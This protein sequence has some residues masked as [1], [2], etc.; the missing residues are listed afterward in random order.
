M[1]HQRGE[2]MGYDQVV[3]HRGTVIPKRDIERETER[4]PNKWEIIPS[5]QEQVIEYLRQKYGD[6]VAK[7]HVTENVK[8]PRFTYTDG[9]TYVK[10]MELKADGLS[11]QKIAD[12]YGITRSMLTGRRKNWML[13][14]QSR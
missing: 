7:V 2:I 6:A 12:R 11:D 4:Y 13:N 8:K 3:H 9:L 1:A 14:P 5:T 10:Y